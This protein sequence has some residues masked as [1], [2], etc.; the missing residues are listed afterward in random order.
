MQYLEK[1]KQK[2][3]KEVEVSSQSSKRKL[4]SVIAKKKKRSKQHRILKTTLAVLKPDSQ[5]VQEEKATNF[6]HAYFWKV[7]SRLTG[8]AFS[9]IIQ[10]L[11]SFE[12]SKI[13]NVADLYRKVENLLAP[14]TDLINEFLIFLLPHQ[15]LEVGRFTDHVLLTKMKE[16]CAKLEVIYI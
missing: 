16:F 4:E 15:A 8:T 3:N 7:R 12:A 13:K 1:M 2:E 9:H 11:A 10:E 6:A 14:H 5:T